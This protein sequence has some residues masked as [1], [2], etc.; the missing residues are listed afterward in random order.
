M[1]PWANSTYGLNNWSFT[2]DGAPSHTSKKTQAWLKEMNPTFLEK[3]FWPPSS[4]DINPLD[5]CLWS[6]LEE[7]ACKKSHQNLDQLKRSLEAAWDS[8]SLDVVR[9]AVD[10]VPKRLHQIVKARGNHIE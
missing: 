10:A 4:P 5:F 1:Y 6:I 7:K 3:D 2:Q 9:A 8:I